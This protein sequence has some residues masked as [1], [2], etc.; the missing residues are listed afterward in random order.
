MVAAYALRLDPFGN[1]HWNNHDLMLGLQC[2]LPVMLL[3]E[4]CSRLS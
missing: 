2:A 3:G 1:L 4:R